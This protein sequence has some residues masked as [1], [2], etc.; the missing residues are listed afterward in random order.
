MSNDIAPDDEHS[1][2][3]LAACHEAGHAVVGLDLG[4][5]CSGLV[6]TAGGGLADVTEIYGDQRAFMVAAGDAA[7]ALAEHNAKPGGDYRTPE[8][9]VTSDLSSP[10]EGSLRAACMVADMQELTQ[11][12]PSDA[13][14]LATWA[15]SGK[16]TEPESWAGRVAFA[17][18][19]AAKAVEVNRDKILTIARRLFTEGVLS[20]EEV[21]KLFRE[22]SDGTS[23]RSPKCQE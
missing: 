16:E 5:R 11:R 1:K 12:Y 3:W 10:I 13:A 20:G 7:A 15:V 14:R 17:R 6:L 9:I 2:R 23:P 8:A 19:I 18:H 4:G 21:T 22:S